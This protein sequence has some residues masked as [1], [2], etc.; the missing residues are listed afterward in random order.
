MHPRYYLLSLSFISLFAFAQ[1]PSTDKQGPFPVHQDQVV[2]TGTYDK[3]P[4]EEVDR[5]IVS[6]PVEPSRVM[7]R[8][9]EDVL[10]NDPAIDIRQRAPGIQ[11]D[12]SLRGSTFGQTLVLVNGLRL[13]DAQSAHHN[14]D[15]PFPFESLQRV[16]I[17]HGSGSTLYGADAVGG[18]VNFITEPPA[19][20]ELRLGVAAGNFG[21]NQQNGLASFIGKKWSEQATFTRELSTG[22]MTDR[23]YRSLAFGS[24]TR[25]SSVLGNTDILFGYSDR[26][27]GANQFYGAYNSWERTK[28]WL[29]ALS[30][31]FGKTQLAFG[32]RRHTDIFVLYRDRPAYYKNDHTTDAYQLALR[33]YE[34]LE[35][36]SRLYYGAEGYR[37]SIDSSSLGAHERNRGAFYGS[38]DI[39][40]LR[41]FSFNIGAREEVYD[42]GEQQFSPSLSGGYW[43]NSRIKLR[44]SISHAFRLPTYTDLYYSD[45]AN[46]GNPNLKPE[47]AWNF[48]GGSQI[49]VSKN[50]VADVTIFHRRDHNVI[51]YVRSSSSAKWEAMNIQDLQ[52]TGIEATLRW[53]L[54]WTSQRLDFGYTGLHGAQQSLGGLQSEYVFNYP[55]NAGTATWWGKLPLN[56]QTRA[57]LGVTQRYRQDAYPLL[58][59]AVSREFTHVKPFVQFT[60]L[61]NTGYE[62]ISGVRMPGHSVLG[63]I[64]L[65]WK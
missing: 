33:R 42:S 63:G 22:F 64:E 32:Y 2:V 55:I 51:D 56:I 62:E 61:T 58:E 44:A 53:Q 18:A 45:P 12:L 31:Q 36:N 41:R 5:T 57:R 59:L 46:M 13:N 27:F 40:A 30:Q 28:G 35:K 17:L 47:S 15:L 52:F 25:A 49:S 14:L 34:Q 26:P 29:A 50:V 19:E 65:R 54:P 1:Q 43:I 9:I 10:Q 7:F 37:E 3:V 23:D 4:L 24:E 48:E 16:E 39:R 20:N 38:I 60:N 21:T 8:N 6:I 11:G